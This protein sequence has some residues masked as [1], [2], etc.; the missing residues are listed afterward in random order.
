MSGIKRTAEDARTSKLVRERDD[1][2]CM[3]C[4]KQYPPNSRG[5]HAAHHFT[6]RTKVTRYDPDNL[7]SLCYGCHQFVDSH[8][9]EKE[10]LWRSRIGDER[11]E[12]LA[13]KA[14]GRRDREVTA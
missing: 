5:L 4:G 12:A 3:R 9:T 1:W 8:P 6:R 11:F 2:T 14:H 13:A 7:L 10:A